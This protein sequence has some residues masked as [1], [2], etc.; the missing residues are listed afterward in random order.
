MDDRP[1][2]LTELNEWV[3]SQLS[4][5]LADVEPGEIDWR[6]VPQANS[7]SA[8]V[9]H[10]R[11]EAHWKLAAL[12]E[13]R[14][15]PTERTAAVDAFVDAVPSDFACNLAELRR[16]CSRFN[17]VLRVTSLAEVERRT[18]PAYPTFPGV[19]PHF[20]AYHHAL[21]LA[22]HWG[23]IRTLRNLY[24]TTRGKPAR[25]IPDNPSFPPPKR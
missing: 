14:P 3:W 15:E 18:P 16:L 1:H 6:P 8:I 23:Q 22:M 21:H 7:I 11:I 9:R 17:D 24:R 13:S 20:L 10:L 4:N 2:V 19:P 12:E 25:F 5:D